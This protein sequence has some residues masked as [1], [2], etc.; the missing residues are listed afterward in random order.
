MLRYLE[1][2][3]NLR[4]LRIQSA[5]VF[6][7]VLDLETPLA[8]A[9]TL[10]GFPRDKLLD[11]SIPLSSMLSALQ[12]RRDSS[13]LL[14][15]TGWKDYANVPF[16]AWV[17]GCHGFRQIVSVGC[18]HVGAVKHQPL[19][20]T[21][22]CQLIWSA[23]VLQALSVL[24]PPAATRAYGTIPPTWGATPQ[25]TSN[26]AVE[27]I[28]AVLPSALLP[29]LESLLDSTGK[30][31]KRLRELSLMSIGRQR[32]LLFQQQLP[33]ERS[34]AMSVRRQKGDLGVEK[35]GSTKK[36][37]LAQACPKRLTP[38]SG[39]HQAWIDSLAPGTNI[40]WAAFAS[41]FHALSR[42]CSTDELKAYY[43]DRRE[44]GA[45]VAA[46]VA[47]RK[48]AGDYVS[49]PT[50]KTKSENGFLKPS[51]ANQMYLPANATDEEA[52][53]YHK[54]IAARALASATANKE[55]A[56]LRKIKE[57]EHVLLGLP[58]VAK[59]T[60]KRVADWTDED[61]HLILGQ[62]VVANGEWR[63][64]P[65]RARV[66][67]ER[68]ARKPDH[69]RQ[70]LRTRTK[71][72]VM[73]EATPDAVNPFEHLRMQPLPEELEPVAENVSQ[74]RCQ[75]NDWTDEHKE[76]IKSLLKWID[77]RW[78]LN[79][80]DTRDL[81]KLWAVDGNAIRVVIKAVITKL[82]PPA[83]LPST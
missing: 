5:E 55:R 12:E 70:V 66:L 63:I 79:P 77:G 1:A 25:A 76:H 75:N 3:D 37:L 81:K 35:A 82:S 26:Q 42:D 71:N 45:K 73:P 64:T 10:T 6:E 30:S 83:D 68:F 52:T 29:S 49:S 38:G 31:A 34:L 11:N 74:T 61:A 48:A 78:V 60:R 20:A 23:L 58:P 56:A 24:L 46:T 15:K 54:R 27:A 41:G 43:E 47:R 18:Y 57:Q 69:I 33:E 32:D 40:S 72:G 36:P 62:A 13:S 67:A 22:R 50:K 8:K 53:A 44:V 59:H 28:R 80:H 9:E 16:L 14:V 17:P 19:L 21:P 51:K 7:L 2:H 4:F 39:E 65:V